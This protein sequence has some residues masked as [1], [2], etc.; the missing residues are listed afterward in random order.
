MSVRTNSQ[1]LD[2]LGGDPEFHEPNTEPVPES[3][4]AELRDGFKEVDGCVVPHCFQDS[5]IWSQT[6]PRTDNIDDETGYECSLSKV[7]LEDFVDSSISLS[8]LARI[9]CAYAMYLRR[10]LL[11]SPVSGQFRIIV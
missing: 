7:H 2:L 11:I 1:M 9:G 8:E 5:S 3:L 6:R 10:A 4:V